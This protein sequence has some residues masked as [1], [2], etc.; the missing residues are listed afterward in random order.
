MLEISFGVSLDLLRSF[1]E[2]VLGKLYLEHI[3]NLLKDTTNETATG[4]TGGPP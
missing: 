3:Q 1:Q 4:L 2:S